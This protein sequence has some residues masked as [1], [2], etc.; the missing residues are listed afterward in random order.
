MSPEID[1]HL[2]SR[3]RARIS[4]PEARIDMDTIPQPALYATAT[5][6][7]VEQTEE[8]LALKLPPFLRQLYLEVGNGGY[9]PGAGLIGIEGG[10]SDFDGQTLVTTY[11]RFRTGEWPSTLL[12]LWDWGDTMWSCVDVTEGFPVVT[13]DGTDGATK[14]TFT[15][16]AFLS[17]WLDGVDLF[18]RLYEIEDA[19]MLNPFTR[20]PIPRKK[21]GRA[22]GIP[23]Y[24]Q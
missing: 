18:A 3:L 22:I 5:L 20:K 17:S 6:S 21:I 23:V 15:L 11:Q 13:H 12:P 1:D 8:A 10:Y 16:Q 24:R 7:D 2:I 9:G 19:T 14:T 4:D